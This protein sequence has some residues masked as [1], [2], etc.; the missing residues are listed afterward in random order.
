VEYPANWGTR[1]K[2]RGRGRGS[3]GRRAGGLGQGTSYQATYA[4]ANGGIKQ[5]VA[6]SVESSES[7]TLPGF[8]N[9]QVQRL[10]SLIESSKLGCEIL[11]SNLLWILDTG[12]SNHMTGNLKALMEL[13]KIEPIPV[14]LP[15]GVIRMATL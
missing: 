6:A 11:S 3:R 4:V 8:T 2:G 1:G 15:N 10:F 5:G 9:E 12:A 7:P 13:E 14:G